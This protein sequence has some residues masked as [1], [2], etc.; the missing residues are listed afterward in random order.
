M[1]TKPNRPAL[2]YHGAKWRLA[3]W[4]ISYL[5]LDY[6]YCEPYAGSAAILLNKT[7]SQLEVIN[8]LDND[9]VNFF[10]VLRDH[11]QK[12]IQKIELTPFSKIEYQLSYESTDDP[13]ENARRFYTRAY[14]A[15][16]GPTA[17]W[18]T[19]WRRQIKYSTH[20]NSTSGMTAAAVSFAKIDHLWTITNRLRG[21]TIENDDALEVI[22]RYD[23]PHAVFYVDPPYV[24]STRSRWSKNSYAHEMSDNDHI[25]LAATLDAIEGMAVI[26]G[27]P[28][29][30]YDDLYRDWD[31][32]ER[33][34]V[35]NASKQA[36]EALWINDHASER[37]DSQANQMELFDTLDSQ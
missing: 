5:P 20:P 31:R 25:Q 1:D 33:T 8:D 28:S 34:A 27:Y 18:R 23:S 13:I 7:R 14:M 24:A 29:D 16:A 9:V 4:I 6:M 11:P 26:S 3:T 22:K 15:I 30:L 12:L 21:V 36:I 10:A 19:G 32:V 35:T 2:R 37:L 17:T